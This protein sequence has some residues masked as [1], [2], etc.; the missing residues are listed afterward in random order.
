MPP[1]RRPD[2]QFDHSDD[3][4]EV[5]AMRVAERDWLEAATPQPAPTPVRLVVARP[6]APQA[7]VPPTLVPPPPPPTP[8][9]APTPVVHTFV[10]ALQGGGEMRVLAV[11]E[12]AARNNVKSSGPTPD[13]G[14]EKRRRRCGARGRAM[15][16]DCSKRGNDLSHATGRPVA[17]AFS[18]PAIPPPP[19]LPLS[20][21]GCRCGTRPRRRHAQRG[22]G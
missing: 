15:S 1:L 5:A 6:S 12:A 17:N 4:T 14:V 11:D 19:W 21:G 2:R 10:V 8:T 13:D 16:A 3:L 7:S 20:A 9:L 22:P 18:K